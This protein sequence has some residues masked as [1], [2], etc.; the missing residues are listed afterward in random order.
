MRSKKGFEMSF[1]WMF[2]IIVGAVIIFLAIYVLTQ[3]FLPTERQKIDIQTATKISILLDPLETSLEAGK[4]SIIEFP[5]ETRIYN[6]R[7]EDSGSFGYQRVGLSSKSGIGEQ[8]PEPS[9]AK[10]LYNKY[11]FSEN[12]EQE[13]IFNVFTKPFDMPFKVSDLIIFSGT[14][15]CLIFNNQ[16]EDIKDEIERLNL[17]N[18]QITSDINNCS[19]KTKKVCF[20]SSIR[21]DISVYGSAEYGGQNFQQGSVIKQGKTMYYT[22]NLLYAA[23]F[24]S[25]D[26]YECNIKRLAKR[27]S[28]LALIYKDKIKIVESKGCSSTLEPHLISLSNLALNASSSE[29]VFSLNEKAKQIDEINHASR[30]SIY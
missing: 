9:Y 5:V 12:I 20:G 27:I 18:I 15:Y 2:S 11:I 29:I 25:S 14:E 21:C 6:D 17:G 1:A 7:C 13:E 3:Y 28:H 26:V 19:S 22:G 4:S 23:I 24:S 8:W 30:C 10:P 16:A